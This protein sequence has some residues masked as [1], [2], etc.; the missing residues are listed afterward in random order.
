M[1]IQTAK[2]TADGLVL[3]G[4]V[5]NPTLLTLSDLTIK[6]SA[7]EPLYKY[8]DQFRRESVFFWFGPP[9]IGEAQTVPIANLSPGKR[10]Q[11]EVTIPN[12]KQTN[13]GIRIEVQFTGER[14]LYSLDN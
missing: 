3:K 2:Y 13:E 1:A 5:G 10:Q 4:Y 9:S 14:Y 12:V 8:R 6:F 7:T 11:F